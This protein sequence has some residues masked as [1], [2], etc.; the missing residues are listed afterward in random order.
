[1]PALRQFTQCNRQLLSASIVQTLRL[2]LERVI[3]HRPLLP[4]LLLPLPQMKLKE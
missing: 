3:V 4:H 2:S 1:M